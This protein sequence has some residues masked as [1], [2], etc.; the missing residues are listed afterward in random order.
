MAERTGEQCE[1]ICGR[2]SP[3]INYTGLHPS[4]N[5]VRFQHGTP[6]GRM[7]THRWHTTRASDADT[8]ILTKRYCG[9][10][11]PGLQHCLQEG[12]T[13]APGCSQY[14]FRKKDLRG[15]GWLTHVVVAVVVSIVVVAPRPHLPFDSAACPSSWTTRFTAA[16]YAGNSPGNSFLDSPGDDAPPQSTI[17]H[18]RAIFNGA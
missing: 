16:Q 6:G 5:E 18:A 13:L 10:Q 3:V 17:A 12:P 7:W 1:C 9:I 4:G 11:R 14:A 2:T 15:P 8:C